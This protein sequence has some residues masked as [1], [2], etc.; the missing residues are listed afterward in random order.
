MRGLIK[1]M[2][3]VSA[4]IGFGSCNWFRT[5]D[6]FDKSNS[7]GSPYEL[8]LVANNQQWNGPLGD[9]LRAILT[10]AVPVL[11]QTEPLFDIYRVLPSSFKDLVAKHRNVLV[12]DIN[13][14][15]K[16]PILG[17]QYDVYSAPQI[18]VTLGAANDQVATEYVWTNREA[19]L[20]VLE[21][22]ERDRS[23][24]NG[25]KYF[26]KGLWQLINKKFGIDMYVPRGYVLRNEKD[27]FVWI[28]YEMPQSSMG[29]FMYSY[30]YTGP[31]DLT[32]QSLLAARNKYAAYI[33]G[34]SEGSYMTTA[35][36]YEPDYSTYRIEGRLWAELR[37][38]WDVAGDYMGGPFVS[39]TTVNTQTNE[40]ITLDCYVYSPSL[41]KRNYMRSLEHLK[42]LISFPG[43]APQKTE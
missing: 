22:A 38:F 9:T 2:I 15:Y 5:V 10:S 42:Y 40:V 1:I 34:P 7:Q 8:I 37:G 28:S 12:V 26:E 39:Y 33:P 14:K 25:K 17:V 30:P 4:V 21:M 35:D 43:D 27:D 24:A 20:Q 16:E 29:F 36:V 31:Q 41:P 6:N 32:L 3:V 19:L 13:P 18:V 11:N 23:I